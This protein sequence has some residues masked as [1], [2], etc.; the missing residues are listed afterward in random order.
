MTVVIVIVV[1]ALVLALW[2]WWAGGRTVKPAPPGADR[3]RRQGE[4][5]REH[6]PTTVPTNPGGI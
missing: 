6:G 1:A 2:A 4:A 5:L 3:S